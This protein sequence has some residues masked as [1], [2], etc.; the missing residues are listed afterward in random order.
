LLGLGL[1]A[2]GQVEWLGL[3]L[4]SLVFAL[5][6]G[7]NAILNAMQNAARQRV[8]VAWH[9][10]L[11]QWLRFLAAV[12][13]VALLGASSS[14][15]MSGYVLA[16]IAVLG[17]QFFFFRRKVLALLPVQQEPVL[18]EV[19]EWVAKMRGYALPF[20]T[21]GF[22]T[23]AQISSARWALQAF[24]ATSDVG[25]YSVLY[26]LGYYPISL[27]STLTARLISPILFSRAGDGAD[28]VRLNQARRW[29]SI[30]V[31][32]AFILAILAAVLAS[33]LHAPIF[34]L[35]AAPAYRSVSPL[36]PW[37]VLSS[38][39]FASG[40]MATLSLLSDI[41]SQ[42]LVAP[43]IATALSGIVLNL[44]GAYWLGVR[45]IVFAQVAFS[46]AYSLWVVI[47]VKSP[48][49]SAKADER[50]V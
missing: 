13:L 17:S 15:A 8:I 49:A 32:A 48:S 11:L 33:L 27:L 12:A 41:N 21:W 10:G 2:L 9:Q 5:F 26:Q 47:L 30:L 44:V 39:L 50:V 24:A 31:L 14:V 7:Y 37:M 18:E 6:A 23:W 20:L 43:K 45:G 22:F 4:S 29:S 46:V 36:L 35:L 16:S 28:P 40:Q 34:E 25:L 1:W 3:A 19:A 38:G 42:G